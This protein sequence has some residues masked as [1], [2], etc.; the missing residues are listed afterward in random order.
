MDNEAKDTLAKDTLYI[1]DG[2]ITAACDESHSSFPLHLIYR[3][4]GGGLCKQDKG[5]CLEQVGRAV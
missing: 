3:Q 5:S 1:G 4:I 2:N